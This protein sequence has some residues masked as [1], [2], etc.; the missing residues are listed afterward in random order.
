MATN[1][2]TAVRIV[3]TH[4][5]GYVN[6]P[7][8]RGGATNFGITQRTLDDCR[9]AT[10]SLPLDVKDLT[11][12]EAIEIYRTEYWPPFNEIGN[13]ET[14]LVLFD[15]AVLRG[16]SR[17]VS[18]VQVLLGVKPDGTMGPQTLAALNRVAGDEFAF[19]MLR[20]SHHAYAHIVKTDPSQAQF[21]E[22]WE[23]RLFSL[24]DFIFF[25]DAS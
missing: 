3:L 4:E 1:F 6:N 20:A 11:R 21:L 17:V 24:A 16:T 25:G 2:D 23:D 10:P 14:A 18:F 5:G 9:R 7:A 19:R 13:M 8:D 12:E 22:G 15:Q